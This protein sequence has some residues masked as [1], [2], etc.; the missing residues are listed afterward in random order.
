MPG[1]QIRTPIYNNKPVPKDLRDFI[2]RHRP[3]TDVDNVRLHGWSPM[4]W[5]GKSMTLGHDVFL[6][7]PA[8]FRD[9]HNDPGNIFHEVE[10][11]DQK[12]NP[13]LYGIDLIRRGYMNIP[14]EKAAYAHQAGLLRLYKNEQASRPKPDRRPT[15][16]APPR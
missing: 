12:I 15:A 14:Q 4:G 9:P 3:S 16:K 1:F 5:D 8:T 10:H 6:A 11:V 2:K 13:F 7:S